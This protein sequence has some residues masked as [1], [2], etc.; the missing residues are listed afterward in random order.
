MSVTTTD[1][2]N[3]LNNELSKYNLECYQHRFIKRISRFIYKIYNN[4]NSP[5]RLK[6]SLTKNSEI[7]SV[8]YN[9]RNKNQFSIPSKGKFN[10]YMEWTFT[11]FYS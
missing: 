7:K 4:N 6:I 1:E 11:Y 2:F 9:L 10:D 5:D 8:I 3:K